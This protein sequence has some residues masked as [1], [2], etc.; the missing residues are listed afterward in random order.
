MFFWL[1]G[2]QR[3]FGF[4]SH[5]TPE[6]SGINTKHVAC[7]SV[8]AKHTARMYRGAFRALPGDAH[9]G[10]F[11]PTII[12][13]E[14]Q[15]QGLQ[16]NGDLLLELLHVLGLTSLGDQ[17]HVLSEE[18]HPLP[19]VQEGHPVYLSNIVVGEL[20]GLILQ[21]VGQ[22]IVKLIVRQLMRASATTAEL[23]RG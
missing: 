6:L 7:V 16:G 12:V 4:I 5:T 23:P 22:V 14:R 9:V 13:D 19:A 11:L 15:P 10:D 20:A 21:R 18:Q 17:G 1:N 3:F 2:F 8:R